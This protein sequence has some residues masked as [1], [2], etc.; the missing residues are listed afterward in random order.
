MFDGLEYISEKKAFTGVDK[1][2]SRC[3]TF[4]A[5]NFTCR[6]DRAR[7]KWVVKTKVFVQSRRN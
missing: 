4:R 6:P 7:K 2:L 1:F 3:P 5:H